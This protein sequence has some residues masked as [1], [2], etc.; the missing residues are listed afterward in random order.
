ME[1]DQIKTQL[2]TIFRDTFSNDSLEI[3]DEMTAADIPEWDSLS[4]L[5][6]VLAVESE[7]NIHLTTREIRDMQSVG[8]LV[9]LIKK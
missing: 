3:K 5:N 1:D 9:E 7:F 6:L 8:D 4:H 2:T